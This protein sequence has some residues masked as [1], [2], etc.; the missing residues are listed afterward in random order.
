MTLD[1]N[2]ASLELSPT[3]LPSDDSL[4]PCLDHLKRLPAL[5][6]CDKPNVHVCAAE[7]LSHLLLKKQT[8]VFNVLYHPETLLLPE[9]VVFF[10]YCML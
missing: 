8:C 5:P 2:T 3:A 9:E 7:Q 6:W 1:L 10:L 4:E